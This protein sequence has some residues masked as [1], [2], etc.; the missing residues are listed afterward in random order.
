VALNVA[1]VPGDRRLTRAIGS[2]LASVFPSVWAWPRL[3]F[4]RS[5]VQAN[6]QA[7]NGVPAGLPRRR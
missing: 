5:H 1:A 3:G 6:R 7:A 2:T 4:R